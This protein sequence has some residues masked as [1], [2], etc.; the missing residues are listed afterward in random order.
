MKSTGN[1]EHQVSSL[2]EGLESIPWAEL[3]H[4][5]GTA[6]DV[7]QILRDRASSNVEIAQKAQDSLFGNILHQG[8]IYEATSHAIPFLVKLLQAREVHLRHHLIWLLQGIADGGG[9]PGQTDPKALVEEQTDIARAQASLEDQLAALLSLI[10]DPDRDVRRHISGLLAK[11][12]GGRAWLLRHAIEQASNEPDV[13][14]GANWLFSLS[15]VAPNDET[16]RQLMKLE[17][18]DNPLLKLAT[19]AVVL[20]CG[21]ASRMNEAAEESTM[22]FQHPKIYDD[23]YRTCG[24][25]DNSGSAENFISLL[26]RSV[27]PARQ[28]LIAAVHPRLPTIDKFA[29]A[30]I[31]E[32]AIPFVFDLQCLPATRGEASVLQLTIIDQMMRAPSSLNSGVEFQI[33]RQLKKNGVIEESP[34]RKQRDWLQRIKTCLGKFK[35]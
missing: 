13:Y 4:A 29:A 14:S 3:H 31:A 2:L 21:D 18:S 8:T 23:Y 10:S 30:M 33:V 20:A 26:R 1:Y 7:P 6:E 34:D 27:A 16:V 11:M 17:P 24:F 25:M 9:Y 32:E 35:T 12:H 22:P 28:A 15:C 19:A 5:Y